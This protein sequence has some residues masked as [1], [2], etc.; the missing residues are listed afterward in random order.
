MSERGGVNPQFF[1]VAGQV[2]QGPPMY[3]PEP[4]PAQG[5]P[6]VVG[7]AQPQYQGPTVQIIQQPVQPPPPL[8]VF[9]PAAQVVGIICEFFDNTCACSH[10]Q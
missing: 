6:Y 8:Q 10:E 3:S 5:Q 7:Y 4:M 1:P 9:Q 2:Q